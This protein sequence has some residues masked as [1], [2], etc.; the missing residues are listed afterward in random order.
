MF[1][2]LITATKTMVDVFDETPFAHGIE[3]WR[4]SKAYH[5]PSTHHPYLFSSNSA[6]IGTECDNDE[7]LG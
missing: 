5:T 7:T 6:G 1:V 3:L 2:R 4:F